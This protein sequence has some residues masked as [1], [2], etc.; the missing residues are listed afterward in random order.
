MVV[1]CVFGG[2][3]FYQ[4]QNSITVV[5]DEAKGLQPG[6]LVQMSGIDI[7]KVRDLTLSGEGIDVSICLDRPARKRLSSNALFVIDPNPGGDKPALVLV[8]DGAS[9]G[10]PLTAQT[11][12]QGISSVT[13]WQLSDLSNQI[14]QMMDSPPV[15]DFVKN[16]KVFEQE[17]DEA[18]RNFDSDDMQKRLEKKI[19]QLT[20]EF[21]QVLHETEAKQ[22]LEQLSSTIA[23]FK[24][25][26][27]RTGDSDEAK[28]LFHALDDL[29]RRVQEEL[30]SRK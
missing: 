15:R 6:A 21:E 27:S 19:S 29:G 23:R 11:R 8:K 26:I 17:M 13:L 12:I 16:L 10:L 5:F 25:G 28:K 22:K 30:T 7:G 14:G 2:W 20:E 9:G 1:A 24:A 3:Q 4:K 18:I